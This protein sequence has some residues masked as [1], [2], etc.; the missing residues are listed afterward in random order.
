MVR[1]WSQAFQAS[2]SRSARSPRLPRPLGRFWGLL[3]REH[4]ARR[5]RQHAE[6]GE[7]KVEAWVFDQI[8]YRSK[9]REAESE[10]SVLKDRLQQEIRLKEEYHMSFKRA[11]FD[12]EKVQERA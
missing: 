5:V 8:E 7:G 11:Q 6:A 4:A 9:L 10:A 1:R 12:L 3:P 2:A